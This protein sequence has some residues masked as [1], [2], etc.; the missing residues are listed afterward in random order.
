MHPDRAMNVQA[1][2]GIINAGWRGDLEAV[3][4]L[5]QQDRGLLDA[6]LDGMSPLTAAAYTGHVEVVRYLLDE[7]ADINL[8]PDGRLTALALAC[9][10]GHLQV[11]ALLLARGARTTPSDGG[12]T[13]LMYAAQRGRT[14]VV[15]LLLAHREGEQLERQ[16]FDYRRTALHRA[17]LDG[18]AG[19]VRALLGA[20]A[21]PHVVDRYGRTPLRHALMEGRAQCV[22]LLQVSI[23]SLHTW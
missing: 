10:P 13:P 22:A 18:H 11:V 21:D 5:V 16:T 4:R 19:V 8:H 9:S 3:R 12:W 7:G 1:A 6:Q 14:G 23:V 15:E 17:C 2:R 20:G